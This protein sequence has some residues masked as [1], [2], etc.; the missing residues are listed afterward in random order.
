MRRAHYK[1][2]PLSSEKR[3]FEMLSGARLV[4]WRLHNAQYVIIQ[5]C[6]GGVA[7]GLMLIN[8]TKNSY[9]RC[10]RSYQPLLQ[11]GSN[12]R[13]TTG[14][15][16]FFENLNIILNINVLYNISPKGGKRDV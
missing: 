10:S 9:S 2:V 5:S 3:S 11:A 7:A 16:Y 12:A 8:C 4:G 15:N 13:E 1:P 6:K 14:N